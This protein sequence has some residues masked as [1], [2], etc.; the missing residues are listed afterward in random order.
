[1]SNTFMRVDEVAAELEVS[2]SY[3]YKIVRRLNTELK[4]MGS[5]N[6]CGQNQQKVF[7]GKSLLRRTQGKEVRAWQ[8]TRK[9]AQTHGV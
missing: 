5:P 6:R 1:M 3:A 2:K 9:P 7:H 8:S 4:N